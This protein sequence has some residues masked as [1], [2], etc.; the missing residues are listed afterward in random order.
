MDRMATAELDSAV[1]NVGSVL[2][3]ATTSEPA[4]SALAGLGHCALALMTVVASPLSGRYR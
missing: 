1:V 4:A 2:D 3:I